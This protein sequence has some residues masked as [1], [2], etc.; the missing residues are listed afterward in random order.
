MSDPTE[1]TQAEL[2][3][4]AAEIF[5]ESFYEAL[6]KPNLRSGITAFYIKPSTLA[7]AEASITLNGNVIPTPSAFQ[8]TFQ[9]KIGKAAYEVQ[10]Y[11]THVINPNYNIGV[12]ESKLGVD[13][14]GRKISIIVMVNGQ[15]KYSSKGGD[16]GEERS[17][18]ENF[19]LVPNMEARNPKA[20][21]DDSITP[22]LAINSG[23]VEF[24]DVIVDGI[25]RAS[26]SND[27]PT[28][29]FSRNFHTFVG[30]V[31]EGNKYVNKS[32][33]LQ[34]T[35][36][37]TEKARN[38]KSNN[39]SA[40]GTIEIQMFRQ[41]PNA[42]KPHSKDSDSDSDI[43]SLSGERTPD[44]GDAQ[45][46]PTFEDYAEWWNLNPCV[47]E[48]ATPNP[49]PFEVTGVNHKKLTNNSPTNRILKK[50]PGD[51]KLWASVKFLLFSTQDFHKLGY[52]DTPD[53]AGT[54]W[55]KEKSTSRKQVVKNAPQTAE[56]TLATGSNANDDDVV[57]DDFEMLAPESEN[58]IN[59]TAETIKDKEARKKTGNSSEKLNSIVEDSYSSS[60]RV[61]SPDFEHIA[62]VS[63]LIHLLNNPQSTVSVDEEA[64]EPANNVVSVANIRVEKVELESDDFYQ[65]NE[66]HNN[67]R[68]Q[69]PISIPGV[70]GAPAY[71][72][73]RDPTRSGWNQCNI[74]TSDSGHLSAITNGQLHME[75]DPILSD[76]SQLLSSANS[77]DLRQSSVPCAIGKTLERDKAAR[78]KS[79]GVEASGSSWKPVTPPASSPKQGTEYFEKFGDEQRVLLRGFHD[80]NQIE[81]AARAIVTVDNYS[82]DSSSEASPTINYHQR[83]ADKKAEKIKQRALGLS[84]ESQAPNRE[85]SFPFSNIDLMETKFDEMI[86]TSA[87][88]EDTEMV[89]AI[90][91]KTEEKFRSTSAEVDLL[92]SSNPRKKPGSCEAGSQTPTEAVS[93]STLE[94]IAK[95]QEDNKAKRYPSSD[96][97]PTSAKKSTVSNQT[98]TLLD[99]EMTDSD[100]NGVL[101]SAS[102]SDGEQNH[103]PVDIGNQNDGRQ[104]SPPKTDDESTILVAPVKTAKQSKT[105]AST[106]AKTSSTSKMSSIPKTQSTSASKVPTLQKTPA[107]KVNSSSTVLAQQAKPKKRVDKG[108]VALVIPD[109][110]EKSPAKQKKP[111]PK[112]PKT[113]KTAVPSISEEPASKPRGKGRAKAGASDKRKAD[114]ISSA[115]SN[116]G[117]NKTNASPA[118]KQT[119]IVERETAAAEARMQAAAEKKKALEEK[120]QAVRDI[121]V[122]MEKAD[123]INKQAQ[124]IEEENAALEAEIAQMAAQYDDE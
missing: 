24:V 5:V 52:L 57:D 80:A 60:I 105:R 65:D 51:F 30:Q 58:G 55:S 97:P 32:F 95:M 104:D 89:D 63:R 117:P 41:D 21:R 50:W 96:I 18:V 76:K 49:P 110:P 66:I 44:L 23:V 8:E 59:E 91:S 108:E 98:E 106:A 124:A 20:P 115:G 1:D 3:T 85:E 101:L 99:T 123:E 12:E 70:E 119:N 45:R 29:Q 15:V 39:P 94:H 38:V 87:R 22:C 120:L 118:L 79:V 43:S 61:E 103:A 25:L 26:H 93:Q 77:S 107:A 84:F 64:D 82:D 11:D 56:A 75:Q 86:N 62:T 78:F 90:E 10:S 7:P 121:K 83:V 68:K 2:A 37:N 36:R 88:L 112:T 46:A 40:V 17:F 92:S 81:S 9:N 109:Q 72:A 33:Q 54:P 53:Y 13:K 122:Q 28:T 69:K 31:K 111:A 74:L 27:K 116:S 102:T 71:N 35:K 19:V 67:R 6:N 42:H 47:D 100:N 113:A 114:Q 48:D 34:V 4:T 73:W 14:D 16:D